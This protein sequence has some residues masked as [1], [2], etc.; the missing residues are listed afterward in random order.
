MWVLVDCSGRWGGNGLRGTGFGLS[1]GREVV[2]GVG[3][4]GILGN[5]RV[6]VTLRA[7]GA[8]GG[9]KV[10]PFGISR[11][12]QGRDSVVPLIVSL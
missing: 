6:A 8:V 2:S 12:R 9:P 5:L 7:V 4:A 3:F 11:N 10:V 1:D